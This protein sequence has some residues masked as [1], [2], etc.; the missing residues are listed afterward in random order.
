M[1]ARGRNVSRP[2]FI[3]PLPVW[4]GRR[5]SRAAPN[6]YCWRVLPGYERPKRVRCRVFSTKRSGKIHNQLPDFRDAD[7]WPMWEETHFKTQREAW[8]QILKDNK[9]MTSMYEE[10]VLTRQR[11]LTAAKAASTTHRRLVRK[12]LELYRAQFT[13]ES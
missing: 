2:M 3:T 9:L 7:G 12:R 11:D 6:R 10:M 13:P 8:Y 4:G 1:A 5:K